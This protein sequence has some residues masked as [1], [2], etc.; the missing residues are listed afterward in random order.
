[1]TLDEENIK[2]EQRSI[3][4]QT[5]L[6]VARYELQLA[7]NALEYCKSIFEQIAK[8]TKVD[9]LQNQLCVNAIGYLNEFLAAEK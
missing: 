8:I 5:D 1:M 3:E 7:T 4:Y 9:T 6:E 2:A